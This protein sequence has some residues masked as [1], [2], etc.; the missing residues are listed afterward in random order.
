MFSTIKI[1]TRTPFIFGIW[2]IEMHSDNCVHFSHRN[3][4]FSEG[5]TV[6]LPNIDKRDK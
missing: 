5:D 2:D 3:E 4:D 6:N 1:V